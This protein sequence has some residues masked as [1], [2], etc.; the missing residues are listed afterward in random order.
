MVVIVVLVAV[1]VEVVCCCFVVLF[2]LVVVALALLL[3]LVSDRLQGDCL[4]LCVVASAMPSLRHDGSWIHVLDRL[5]VVLGCADRRDASY[6]GAE[7][8]GPGC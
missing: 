1:V 4:Q 3:L 7:Q 2:L 8:A 5:H 6:Q